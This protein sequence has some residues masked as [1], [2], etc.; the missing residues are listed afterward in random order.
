[1]HAVTTS[2][3]PTASANTYA[4]QICSRP[5][6]SPSRGFSSTTLCRRVDKR[7]GF[8]GHQSCGC[9]RQKVVTHVQQGSGASTKVLKETAA[10]DQLIDLFLGA[11]SQQ[12][13]RNRVDK[14]HNPC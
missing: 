14:L 11:K 4:N 13:V 2:A 8:P 6:R 7:R 3:L 5:T 1:M 12:Q 9:K 10:L